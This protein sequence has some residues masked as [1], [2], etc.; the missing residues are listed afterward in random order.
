MLDTTLSTGAMRIIGSISTKIVT[1]AGHKPWLRLLQNLRASCATDWVERYPNHVV[2][3]WLGHSPMIAATHYLQTRERH[4]KDVVTGA[5]D[6]VPA[7]R[8]KMLLRVCTVVCSQ[9]PLAL[10]A[11]RTNRDN[12]AE[13]AGLCETMRFAAS[14]GKTG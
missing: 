2:A 8:R 3:K 1:R 12:L 5:G 9:K 6:R 11:A 14:R 7:T 13:N 4:F 10:A